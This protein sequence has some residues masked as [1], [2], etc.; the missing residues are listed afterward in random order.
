MTF[1]PCESSKT[2][3][4][5]GTAVVTTPATSI[6]VAAVGGI[7]TY[8]HR[9]GAIPYHSALSY[10]CQESLKE[11]PVDFNCYLNPHFH[12]HEFD[13]CILHSPS[14]STSLKRPFIPHNAPASSLPRTH[15]T[16]LTWSII[17]GHH[18]KTDQC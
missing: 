12:Y 3:V 17:N 13:T 7:G 2:S 5:N 10:S 8:R 1:P 6:A 15:F 9:Y 18:V 4:C 14:N 16:L 11:A